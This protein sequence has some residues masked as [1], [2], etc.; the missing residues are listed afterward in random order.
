MIRTLQW[1]HDIAVRILVKKAT[2]TVAILSRFTLPSF[3][4]P[5]SF[6]VDTAPLISASSFLPTIGW[7][8]ARIG[9]KGHRCS[10]RNDS[11]VLSNAIPCNAE[12][13]HDFLQSCRRVLLL[14]ITA[15]ASVEF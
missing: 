14:H 2:P 6:I 5:A 7:G 15:P 1:V 9:R 4:F 11:E 8:R 12:I 10:S 13:R 3:P